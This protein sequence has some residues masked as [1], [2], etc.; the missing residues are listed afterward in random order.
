MRGRGFGE[1]VRRG[2][3]GGA[4]WMFR[5]PCGLTG[6]PRRRARNETVPGQS[7]SRRGPKAKI[8]ASA[9]I[10]SR[11]PG[12]RRRERSGPP[13][14][15][16]GREVPDEKD[17]I[18]WQAILDNYPARTTGSVP[19]D[20]PGEDLRELARSCGCPNPPSRPLS[21]GSTATGPA[22]SSGSMSSPEG[23]GGYA[24]F[25]GCGPDPGA[26]GGARGAAVQE[27]HEDQGGGGG[28]PAG[29]RQAPGPPFREQ[30]P[31]A[32]RRP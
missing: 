29:L 32:Q 26:G 27:R 24:G 30:V 2:P 21:S 6:R 5:R 20:D 31:E 10:R 19:G 4:G 18:D 13:P 22:A 1:G 7:P 15:P 23:A 16:P 8:P 3:D 11:P 9:A 17:P 28:V 25:S 12:G 14:A